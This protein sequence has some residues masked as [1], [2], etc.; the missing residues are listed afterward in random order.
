M[1]ATLERGWEMRTVRVKKN[2]VLEKMRANVEAHVKEY[3]DACAA[4]RTRAA[5]V[6]EER[7]LQLRR[8][9]TVACSHFDLPAPQSHEGDYKQAIAM[10]EMS[11]DDVIEL[12]TDEFSCYVLDQWQWQGQFKAINSAYTGRH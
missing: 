12:L 8:G 9:E 3:R 6:L 2:E 10:L 7:A 5:S 11:V 1:R 4:Y